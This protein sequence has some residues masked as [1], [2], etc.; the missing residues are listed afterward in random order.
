MG[1]DVCSEVVAEGLDVG[2]VS[3]VILFIL[4]LSV[5]GVIALSSGYLW[6]SRRYERRKR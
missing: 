5:T 2:K 3:A 1:V 4:L 6:L